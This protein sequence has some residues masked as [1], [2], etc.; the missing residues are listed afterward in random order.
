MYTERLILLKNWNENC[1][2]QVFGMVVERDMKRVERLSRFF[3]H[4]FV[5]IN[6][7]RISFF[8]FCLLASILNIR[9]V[10]LSRRPMFYSCAVKNFSIWKRTQVEEGIA[11]FISFLLFL[12]WWDFYSSHKISATT[13]NDKCERG[14]N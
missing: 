4:R 10:V 1:S 14:R 13:L 6:L 7:I 11:V 5:V 8:I 9:C 12:F 2:D 3:F